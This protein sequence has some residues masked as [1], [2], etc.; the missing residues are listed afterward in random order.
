MREF[1]SRIATQGINA[2]RPSGAPAQEAEDTATVDAVFQGLSFRVI[3]LKDVSYKDAKSYRQTRRAKEV[4]ERTAREMRAIEL[5]M[6]RDTENL[7]MAKRMSRGEAPTIP[8][9]HSGGDNKKSWYKTMRDESN[10][11]FWLHTTRGER[12][13]LRAEA[14]HPFSPE[15]ETLVRQIQAEDRS[16]TKD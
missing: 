2:V 5:P 12:D 4:E 11:E 9:H 13:S 3:Q 8:S 6:G 7:L 16:H 1:L 10:R 15:L 14:N